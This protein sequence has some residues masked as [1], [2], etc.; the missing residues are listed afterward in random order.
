MFLKKSHVT[1][2]IKPLTNFFYE[3][4]SPKVTLIH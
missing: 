2:L 4:V 3:R 1:K